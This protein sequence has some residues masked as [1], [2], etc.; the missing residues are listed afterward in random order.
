M[1]KKSK[2]RVHGRRKHLAA[3]GCDLGMMPYRTK[4]EAEQAGN[5][6]AERCARCR[7]WHNEDDKPSRR[8]RR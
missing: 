6:K 7:Q 2:E 1:A 4:Q 3:G 8:G 5:G